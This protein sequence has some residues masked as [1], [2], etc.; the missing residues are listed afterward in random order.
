MSKT[1]Y[2]DQDRGVQCNDNVERRGRI[3]SGVQPTENTGNG[4]NMGFDIVR[5]GTH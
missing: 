2:I 4:G 5:L 1:T 3:N